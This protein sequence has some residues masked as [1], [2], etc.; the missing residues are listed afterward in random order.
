MDL[1]GFVNHPDP[2]HQQIEVRAYE[3]WQE[4]GCPWGTPETDWFTAEQE[5]TKPEA[6]L[7]RVAREVGTAMGAVVALLP[8]KSLLPQ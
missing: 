1:G 6:A 3:Y 8:H 2:V 7:S 5:L 4:R